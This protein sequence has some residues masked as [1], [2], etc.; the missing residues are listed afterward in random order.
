LNSQSVDPSTGRQSTPPPAVSII[1]TWKDRPVIGRMIRHN[2]PFLGNERYET[3]IVNC[4]GDRQALDD[5]L[6]GVGDG[7]VRII[8]SGREQFNKC[9]ALNVGVA[10]STGGSL[11]FLDTDVIMAEDVVGMAV[12]RLDGRSFVTI[13]WLIESDTRTR[14]A[15]MGD[16]EMVQMM[17]LTVQGG[18]R[19]ILLET[20]RLRPIDGARFGGG[21]I[22]I[23]RRHFL[24]VGGMNSALEGWGW[25][26]IDLI[27]RLQF[28]LGLER[29][30]AGEVTH[31]THGDEERCLRGQSRAQSENANWVKCMTSYSAGNFTGTY[32][33]DV[34]GH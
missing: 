32:L 8:D 10:A 17:E 29:V 24:A 20:N 22:A 13:K 26:D 1:I 19:R 15:V 18:K 14:S 34:A 12:S 5:L 21:S 31:L 7:R 33:E 2:W 3:V 11:F 28:A 25:E 6:S 30:Q 16:L 23:E 4:G 9:F 27:A